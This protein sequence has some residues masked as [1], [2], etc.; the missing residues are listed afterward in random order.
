MTV[1][2]R[3]RN[4]MFNLELVAQDANIILAALKKLP[5]DVGLRTLQVVEAQ[6]IEQ[7]KA[8]KETL[9]NEGGEE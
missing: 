2:N 6:L 1:G 3:R 4:S 5:I 8:L 7:D 9:D